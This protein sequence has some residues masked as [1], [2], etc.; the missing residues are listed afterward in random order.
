MRNCNQ[1]WYTSNCD[2]CVD[3]EMN[4]AFLLIILMKKGLN[5]I[6]IHSRGR[7][8]AQQFHDIHYSLNVNL[9]SIIPFIGSS[10][11]TKMN[12]WCHFWMQRRMF[13]HGRGKL[14]LLDVARHSSTYFKNAT[15]LQSLTKTFDAIP[16]KIPIPLHLVLYVIQNNHCTFFIH[17]QSSL[18]RL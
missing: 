13:L 8:Q 10:I 18:T 7:N 17:F 12:Y 2:V 11:W 14:K 5:V 4:E 1:T 15:I 16:F 9:W 3:R 6:F